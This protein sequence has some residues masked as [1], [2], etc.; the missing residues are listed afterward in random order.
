[1]PSERTANMDESNRE[2]NKTELTGEP[3]GFGLL[4]LT[5]SVSLAIVVL[6]YIRYSPPAPLSAV[7]ASATEFSA[8]RADAILKI[9]VG[10]GIPHPAGSE[11]IKIVR[12]RIVELLEEWGYDAVKQETQHRLLRKADAEQIPLV[13]VMARLPGRESGPATMLASHY[14][15]RTGPGA[16][17]DGVGTAALLEIARM[18]KSSPQQ[19]NDVIFLITDGEEKGLLGADKFVEQHPWAKD[20]GVV[21]NLEARG[22]TGPSLMFETSEDS[23]WL[24]ELFARAVDRP[25]AT[26]LFYEIYKFLPNDT[27]FTIF[28]RAGMQGYNFA[29]IGDVKNYHTLDDNYENADRGSLQ[30]HGQNSWTLIRELVEMDLTNTPKG[31]AVYFD[32]FG[33][34]LVWWPE[35]WS[36]FLSGI[37]TLALL[38]TVLIRRRR[39]ELARGSLFTAILMVL[40]TLLLTAATVWLLGTAFSMDQRFENAWIESPVPVELAC[41][42]AAIGCAVL[43]VHVLPPLRNA[44]STWNASL[45]VWCVFALLTSLGLAGASYLFLVPTVIAS[46]V[47][48]LLG[49]S[50]GNAFQVALFAFAAST[51]FIWLPNEMLFYDA[52]G[53]KMKIG[54][55]IRIAIVV[56]AFLPILSATGTRDRAVFGWLTFGGFLACVVAAIFLN[57][58]N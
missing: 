32:V 48:L 45:L 40:L 50:K 19:R 27:D 58:I 30:H 11:H 12:Q 1:M 31:K 43:L 37:S 21:I 52:V 34:F 55:A 42:F 56:S 47:G 35:A 53:F 46:F 44:Q 57:P 38:S 36:L 6:G 15:A 13:N 5:L 49:W 16:S 20:V 51:S 4:A 29:Y 54:M 33:W 3:R 14:D 10:D 39:C 2:A 26:S 24:I 23:R 18:M 7:G 41:W 17:D 22:T 28:R 25:M 9:L 8:E